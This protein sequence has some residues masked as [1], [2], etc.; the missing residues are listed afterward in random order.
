[1]RELFSPTPKSAEE[2]ETEREAQGIAEQN[3]EVRLAQR[4][5]AA[6]IYQSGRGASQ[7][8]E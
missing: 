7:N 3:A 2:L 5:A 1:M 6:N 8:S 4:S